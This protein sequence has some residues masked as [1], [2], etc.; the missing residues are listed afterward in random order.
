MLSITINL[1]V[2]KRKA[3]LLA[4]EY[5]GA[6]VRR[7]PARIHGRIFCGRRCSSL[8]RCGVERPALRRSPATSCSGCGAPLLNLSEAA[9]KKR[10]WFCAQCRLEKVRRA[11]DRAKAKHPIV[12][13]ARVVPKLTPQQIERFHSCVDRSSESC[14]LWKGSLDG[15]GYGQFSIDNLNF[16]A[17]RVSFVLAGRTVPVGLELDHLCRVR[18]CVNPAHLEPVTHR[19]NVRRGLAGQSPRRRHYASAKRD[20]PC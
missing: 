14:W 11:R 7:E 6:A 17:H 4:C 19:E 10:S 13:C 12:G 9:L 2:P 3:V 20:I 8:S 18:R 5:C 1:P 15:K 16:V